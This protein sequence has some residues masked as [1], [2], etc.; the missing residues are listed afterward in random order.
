MI[1]CE[2]KVLLTHEEYNAI[3]KHKNSASTVIH[4]KNHYF[5]TDDFS[6]NK[7]GI[8]CRI[9]DKDGESKATIKIHDN[10][11]S[12]LSIEKTS[13]SYGE[14]SIYS[15]DVMGLKHQGSLFTERTILYKDQF[16]ELVLDRNSYLDY[17]DYELEIEYEVDHENYAYKVLQ[18]V[19]DKLVLFG[20]NANA[21]MFIS[22][23][24]KA[25]SKSSRFFELKQKQS[26]KNGVD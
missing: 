13:I 5:D 10:N 1:E 2:K 9:R 24:G 15:F 19:A 7:K 14:L 6:M 8:T 26:M 3:I 22:R 21:E 20:V 18:A 17:I 25:A 4:Q 16:C 11:N 23:V 12:D